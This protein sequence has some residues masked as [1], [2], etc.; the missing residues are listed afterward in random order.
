MGSTR[1]L[2]AVLVLPTTYSRL[3]TLPFSSNVVSTV[4]A[5]TTESVLFSSSKSFHLSASTSPIR[6]PANIEVKQSGLNKRLVLI[7]CKNRLRSSSGI[8]LYS[9]CSAAFFVL[10]SCDCS[11]TLFT[12]FLSMISSSMQYSKYCPSWYFT[13]LTVSSAYPSS[14]MPPRK[15][16]SRLVEISCGR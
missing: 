10:R 16:C 6:S 12:G 13:C 9:C 2:P 15:S 7:A 4:C 3:T 5:R 11:R 8:A 1:T 14:S